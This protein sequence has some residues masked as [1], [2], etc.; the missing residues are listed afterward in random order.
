MRIV[1]KRGTMNKYVLT[2]ESTTVG[3][4]T[5]L[6]VSFAAEHDFPRGTFFFL[7]FPKWNPLNPKVDLRK[8][9]I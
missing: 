1:A 4:S 9:Y 7:D 8:P 3:A 6:K 5:T 2:P